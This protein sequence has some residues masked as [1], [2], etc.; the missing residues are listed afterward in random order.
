VCAWVDALVH[1]CMYV[2][3]LLYSLGSHEGRKVHQTLLMRIYAFL[4]ISRSTRTNA[5]DSV[6]ARAAHRISHQ[7]NKPTHTHT[8]YRSV[9]RP[10]SAR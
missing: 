2:C 6:R 5:H 3:I 7:H 4:P 1:V 10:R 9:R 8:H